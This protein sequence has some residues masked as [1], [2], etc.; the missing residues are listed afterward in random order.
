MSLD[1]LGVAKVET[2]SLFYC[3]KDKARQQ[4]AETVN[5]ERRKKEA[6]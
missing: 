1:Y 4:V 6:M 3:Y 5:T 2:S